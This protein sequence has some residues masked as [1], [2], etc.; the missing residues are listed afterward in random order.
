MASSDMVVVW[1]DSQ[2]AEVEFTEQPPSAQ[3]F[4]AIVPNLPEPDTYPWAPSVKFAKSMMAE[5]VCCTPPRRTV[6]VKSACRKVTKHNTM[7]KGYGV[8]GLHYWFL[9]I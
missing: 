4:H 5:A 8:M 1:D 7:F 2:E 9:S 6:V 3:G